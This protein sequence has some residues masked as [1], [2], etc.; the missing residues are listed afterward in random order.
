METLITDLLAFTRMEQN[1]RRYPLEPLNL[2][3]LV[4]ETAG[5][6]ELIGEKG[7]TLSSEI[8]DNNTVSGNRTLLTQLMQNLID[9][10]FRYGRENGHILV[11]LSREGGRAVLSV[12]DDGIGIPEAEQKKIF[13]RFYR[14]DHS[15]SGRGTGLGLSIAKKIVEL[16]HT[17]ISVESEAGYGSTLRSPLNWIPEPDRN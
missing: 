2:S 1:A 8:E 17:S 15:R 6:M 10:A 12:R 13:D 7:I 3:E 16:H 4:H 11:S 9:N 5:Q 14:G